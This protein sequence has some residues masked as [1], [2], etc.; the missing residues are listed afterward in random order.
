MINSIYVDNIIKTA[1]LED[2]NYLDTT[3]DYLIDEDQENTARFLAKA[4][5]VLC[6]IDVALRVFTIL[7]EQGFEAKVYKH[8][9]DVLEKGDIIA[10]IRGKTR[11]LLKGERTALNLLQHMS[12][13]AT[14]TGQAVKAIEGT[15]ASIA[16]TRK[17]LPGL[18]P[19]QK[20]AV[21]VGGGKNH[22][23]NLSDAAMLKDNHVDAGGGIA[24]AVAKLRQKLGHMT[25]IELEVRSLDELGQALEAGVD[26]IML[27]N[28]SCEEMREA[29]AITN[30]RALLEASGGITAETLRAIAETGVDIISMGAL[31]HSV[32]AFDISLK[33]SC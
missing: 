32:T 9:G 8:D 28:M 6:G 31:T 2:I 26:V 33:I 19:L 15:N 14:A 3:T 25:K 1:L 7:Q 12:G 5:G 27:D 17:T 20:Y 29:V 10:E 18:R 22:R 11:T 13:V 21:T 30:G 4:D 24:S 23:Y 16:D